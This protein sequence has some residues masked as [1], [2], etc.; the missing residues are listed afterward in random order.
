MRPMIEVVSPDLL[1]AVETLWQA[2]EHV[3]D[4]LYKA[5]A[6]AVLRQ[7]CHSIY[8]SAGSDQSLNYALS[9]AI[10][11]LG[12]RW[13]DD[14]PSQQAVSAEIAASRIDSAFRQTRSHRT[15]LCPLDQ[16]DELSPRHF[17]PNSVRDFTSAE[18]DSLVDPHGTARSFPGRRLDT[19]RLS[20][21]TWLVVEEVIDLPG[22]P[23]TRA[24]P[25]L[26]DDL[27]ADFGRIQPHQSRYPQ[28]VEAALFALLTAPWEDVTVHSDVEWRP[29]RVPWVYT[30]DDD[31]FARIPR[32][33]SAGSLSW[34]PGFHQNDSGETIEY[35]R[36]FQLMLENDADERT[37]YLND[38]AWQE[39]VRA[40]ESPLFAG[41]VEHF[42]VRAFVS[43][44]I[45]EFLA[46]ILVI[47]A[48]L[49]LSIDQSRRPKLTDNPGAT[50]RVGARLSGLLN[51][52]TA[53][54]RYLELFAERS[55]FLHGRAMSDIPSASRLDARRLARR[56]VCA[57][58][59]SAISEPPPESRDVFLNDLLLRS[60]SA[61][62]QS[63]PD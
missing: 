16:A 58:I 1:R 38:E 34:E 44:G 41:P 54:T 56:C 60:W 17:G 2:D 52:P 7:V 55:R 23:D 20:Q 14:H 43:D 10:Y 30:C 6:F 57:L 45:D 53:G 62:S 37:K 59:E 12:F 18:L 51:D 4:N 19:R 61:T 49:G 40:R 48:A 33:P 3:P 47:E 32:P 15:H 8:P 36:P 31:L 26:F 11:N 28:P 42:F 63:I 29:F 13:A 9:Q 39:L 27:G 21:F 25:S 50:A 46:H 35:E 24:L 22:E 5:P